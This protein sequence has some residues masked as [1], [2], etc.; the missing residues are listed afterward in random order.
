MDINS[1]RS[2]IIYIRM[3][4]DRNIKDI[5]YTIM[6]IVSIIMDV[7]NI[8]MDVDCIKMD[9]EYICMD[10]NNI[11][12]RMFGKTWLLLVIRRR[13]KFENGKTELE[14]GSPKMEEWENSRLNEPFGR[15]RQKQIILWS[16]SFNP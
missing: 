2:D 9:N 13:G 4:V 6:E 8:S 5:N 11:K 12:N 16:E 10:I 7:K 15:G 14:D 1:K 3:D